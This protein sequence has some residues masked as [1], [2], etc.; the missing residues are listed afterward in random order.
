LISKVKIV[1]DIIIIVIVSLIGIVVWQ[2]MKKPAADN[3]HGMS[4][5]DMQLT[6]ERMK[7]M[8]ATD[9]DG[10]VFELDNEE[11]AISFDGED[12]TIAKMDMQASTH[13]KMISMGKLG[14]TRELRSEARRQAIETIRK[15]AIIDK[16]VAE[17]DLE[18]PES[19][20]E[21]S[22]AEIKANMGGQEPFDK[23]LGSMNITE[24]NLRTRIE[25]D[26]LENLL[27][28]AVIEKLELAGGSDEIQQEAFS[29]WLA[30]ELNIQEFEIRESLLD[31][32]IVKP[33]EGMKMG[34]GMGMGMAPNGM[35]GSMMNP[36]GDQNT[37][38]DD[39]THNH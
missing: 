39:P 31:D 29:N 11:I 32:L 34:S 8:P 27:F 1:R 10:T 37:E 30:N 3:A 7:A 14:L 13:F 21:S 18:I 9:G 33:T 24:E 36:S 35:G 20:I 5:S 26:D 12:I 15:E 2:T 16:A 6:M 4:D 19:D 22:L 23:M 25:K 28:V 38:C 17:F